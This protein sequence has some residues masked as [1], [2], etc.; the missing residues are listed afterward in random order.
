MRCFRCNI[1][2][3]VV[4]PYEDGDAD[5]HCIDHPDGPVEIVDL[6]DEWVIPPPPLEG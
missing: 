4:A 1:C 3:A 2:S 5:A 6:P